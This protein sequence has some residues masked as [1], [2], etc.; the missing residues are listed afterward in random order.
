MVAENNFNNLLKDSINI[1]ENTSKEAI[2]K[3]QSEF[4]KSLQD[5]A[6]VVIQNN[7]NSEFLYPTIIIIPMII[8]IITIMTLSITVFTKFLLIFFLI[9]SLITYILEY[10][11]CNIATPLAKISE[12]LTNS[13]NIGGKDFKKTVFAN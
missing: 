12:K 4:K 10:K 7:N 5:K 1:N 6:K 9:I 3:E 8:V 2:E 11:K 13:L